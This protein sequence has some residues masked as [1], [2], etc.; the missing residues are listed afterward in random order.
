MTELLVLI[1]EDKSKKVVAQACEVITAACEVSDLP[2]R[3]RY[4]P[5]TYLF[6]LLFFAQCYGLGFVYK[7]MNKL[8]ELLT[9][10]LQEKSACQ[11]SQ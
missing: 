5:L 8:T 10:L 2:L 6:L 9:K 11:R 3:S 4:P 1:E 7:D